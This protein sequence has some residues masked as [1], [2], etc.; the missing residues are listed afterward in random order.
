MPCPWS[1]GRRKFE[2]D[3]GGFTTRPFNR[4]VEVS[5]LHIQHEK[6]A[7]QPCGPAPCAPVFKIAQ[8]E[9]T[10]A[11]RRQVWEQRRTQKKAGYARPL[12][13]CRDVRTGPASPRRGAS[14]GKAS[15][16][17]SCRP[18]P[19]VLV[20]LLDA[21]LAAFT[22]AVL[23]AVVGVFRGLLL[24]LIRV[25]GPLR[26][27]GRL[28]L[29]RNRQGRVRRRHHEG[30]AILKVRL[31]RGFPHKRFFKVQARQRTHCPCRR[32]TPRRARRGPP[33]LLRPRSSFAL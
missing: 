7:R 2:R 16:H 11:T 15:P 13:R 1:G 18:G 9:R 17:G 31:R 14:P 26:I 23:A 29:P 25:G 6:P 19:C 21:A 4:G 3:P 12:R 27:C 28:R 5:Q 22:L 8:R 24:G 32:R 30:R 33:P 20:E 10:P